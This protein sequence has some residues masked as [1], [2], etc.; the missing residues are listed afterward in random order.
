MLF[1]QLDKLGLRQDLRCLIKNLRD[2]RLSLLVGLAAA[3]FGALRLGAIAN[4]AFEQSCVQRYLYNE[5]NMFHGAN[6]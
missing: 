2:V 6:R 4:G 1:A 3:S 5:I